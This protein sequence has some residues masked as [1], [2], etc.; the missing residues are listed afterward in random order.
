MFDREPKRLT[1]GWYDA[2]RLFRRHFQDLYGRL[3]ETELARL[4]HAER[5][6]LRELAER[7]RLRAELRRW[8]AAARRAE[9]GTT[10]VPSAR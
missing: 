6:T 9:P 10:P 2:E 5:H 1:D 3:S 8:A 7:C 4:L